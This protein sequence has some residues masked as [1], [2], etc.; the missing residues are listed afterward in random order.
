MGLPLFPILIAVGLFVW[1]LTRFHR[2]RF[3]QGFVSE[4]EPLI[5]VLLLSVAPSTEARISQAVA[6][7]FQ[8]V[9]V[10]SWL[11][12]SVF[13]SHR[14]SKLSAFKLFRYL[15]AN[16]NWIEPFKKEIALVVVLFVL[17]TISP[18]LFISS[19]ESSPT[20]AAV[21]LLYLTTLIAN[22]SFRNQCVYSITS[23]LIGAPRSESTRRS[24]AHETSLHLISPPDGSPNVICVVVESLSFCDSKLFGGIRDYHQTLDQLATLGTRCIN[25]FA[26]GPDSEHGLIS[27]LGGFAPL[28]LGHVD[29]QYR[30]YAW[31][32]GVAT[33]Y[34]QYGY[35]TGIV[36]TSLNSMGRDLF[37]KRCGFHDVWSPENTSAFVDSPRF[38]LDA[39]ADEVLFRETKRI[40][41]SY[42]ELDH[43]FFVTCYTSSS[44][45]PYIN[46]RTNVRDEKGT[47][48]YVGATLA[49]FYHH[50]RATGFFANGIFIV[51]GDHRK[52]APETPDERE[53][54]GFTCRARI[55]LFLIGTGVPAGGVRTEVLDH[56]N[57][58][59]VLPHL[60]TG[61][62]FPVTLPPFFRQ[63][64]TLQELAFPLEGWFVDPQDPR[65]AQVAANFEG[66]R[67]IW[68][69]D[70]RRLGPPF[71][72]WIDTFVQEGRAAAIL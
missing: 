40:I 48:D 56:S 38:S 63:R 41:G 37:F 4:L 15:S 35:S 50:L 33:P 31:N 51:T 65:K 67:V 32:G 58:F 53:I 12:D 61:R 47:W 23:L 9:V 36:S 46:P 60:A 16:S 11:I 1:R 68:N 17:V 6:S 26:N 29:A 52:F 55:P 10:V 5:L 34:K 8:T 24:Q 54:L 44:H 30:H 72:E 18:V 59:R 42:Q 69:R 7:V 14:N 57:L 70:A 25:Y 20:T 62:P 2:D 43:P 21:T 49:D 27:L 28:P 71:E 3:A 19:G 64:Y 39:V 66:E 13:Q 45:I 22:F